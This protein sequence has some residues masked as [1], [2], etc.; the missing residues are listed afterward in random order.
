MRYLALLF[1][2]IAGPA[3]A[4]TDSSATVGTSAS[5]VLSAGSSVQPRINI[6]LVNRSTDNIW[7]S[8]TGT[9]TVAGAGTF[10][11]LGQG[12]TVIYAAPQLVPQGALS[13]IS[14]GA[15]SGLTVLV[16]P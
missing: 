1:L 8:W 16:T 7:C 15:S 12:A 5:N 13:C 14:S 4:I 10:P 2:L 9:A 3:L 11:L 6:H